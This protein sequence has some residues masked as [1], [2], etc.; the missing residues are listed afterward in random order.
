MTKTDTRF[1]T[2][3]EWLNA[4]AKAIAT[5][6]AETF[7]EHFGAEGHEHLRHLK[8]STGFPATRGLNGKVIG[9]CW[10]AEAAGDTKS[11]HI[12]VSPLLTEPV[13]VIATLAH[14]MVHAADNGEHSH[15]GPFVRAVRALGLEGKPTATVAGEAFKEYATKLILDVLGNYPHTGLT[16]LVKKKVQKTYM[17]KLE[18]PYCGCIVRMTRTWLDLSGAPFCGTRGHI[19]DGKPSDK[20]VRLLDEEQMQEFA[21]EQRAKKAAATTKKKEG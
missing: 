10:K 4:A 14:E 2:R 12:F 17:L 3:E 8:V 20:R 9:E 6:F 18:C 1:K 15:R 16:P 7:T 5:D 21:K 13:K 11:H 19:I